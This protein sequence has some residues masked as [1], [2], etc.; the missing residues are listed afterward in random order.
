MKSTDVR[1]GNICCHRLSS[2]TIG[3]QCVI[4][5]VDIVAMS[6][7]ERASKKSPYEAV[8]L[9]EEWLERFGL[10]KKYLANPFED[11]GYD[12]KEDGSRWYYWVEGTFHLEVQPSGEIWF[13]IYSQYMHIE[14]VHELQNLYHGTTKKDLVLEAPKEPIKET[15][16]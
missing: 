6:Q 10:I 13:E 3:R 4:D 7:F 8:P 14:Y 5:A 16:Q 2:E 9:T 11:G 12:L 1:I 15:P